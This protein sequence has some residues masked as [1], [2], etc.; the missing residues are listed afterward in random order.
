MK[1]RVQEI[2]QK[3]KEVAESVLEREGG[4]VVDIQLRLERKSVLV[5]LFIDTD[6]GITIDT[7]A[8]V[9]RELRSVLETQ[10][11]LEETDFR[12]E[13]SSPGIDR[14]LRLLRQYPKNIGR[15]FRVQFRTETEPGSLMAILTA[16][17]G[18]QLTFQPDGGEPIS[19]SFD[20]IIESQEELP[21]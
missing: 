11:T 14:S 1:M 13:V 3:I 18:N 12:M 9:S 17:E 10:R 16:V 15:R 21:W 7:C 5:Q 8:R 20:Q 2:S 6:K 4:F 19:L